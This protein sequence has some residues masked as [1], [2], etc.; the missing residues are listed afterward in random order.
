V[1]LLTQPTSEQLPELL[2]IFD[3]EHAHSPIVAR[4][5]RGG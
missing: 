4:G 3:H 5:M 1:A 2:L